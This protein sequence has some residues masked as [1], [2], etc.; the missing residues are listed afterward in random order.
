MMSAGASYKLGSLSGRPRGIDSKEVLY[1]ELKSRER[2][3]HYLINSAMIYL[4]VRILYFPGL[5]LAQSNC[6][7]K[8]S[9]PSTRSFWFE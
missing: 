4:K 7:N 1:D 3:E 2:V 6:E 8:S 5:K 9:N